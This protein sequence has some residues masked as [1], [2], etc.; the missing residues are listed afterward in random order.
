MFDFFSPRLTPPGS[1][2]SNSGSPSFID[3]RVFTSVNDLVRKLRRYIRPY[4]K[5]ARPFREA[6]TD[7]QLRIKPNVITGIAH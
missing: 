4:K 5:S 6:Y 1:T 7:P 2:K 3:H